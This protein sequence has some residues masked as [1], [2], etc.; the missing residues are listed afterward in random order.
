[1]ILKEIKGITLSLMK[2]D[3]DIKD[4][5]AEYIKKKSAKFVV[6]KDYI[7]DTT[8]VEHLVTNMFNDLNDNEPKD[9]DSLGI[10]IQHNNGEIIDNSISLRT[11]D[12]I[13]EYSKQPVN[14]IYEF[15]KM[16]LNVN[17]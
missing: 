12:S 7:L 13:Q 5:K 8:I 17:D 16:T 15:F 3:T 11:L 9:V 10:W 6:P 2:K 1:M 4:G 14:P